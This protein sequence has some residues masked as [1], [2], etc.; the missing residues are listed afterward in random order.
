MSLI[1][2]N[3]DP[4]ARYSTSTRQYDNLRSTSDAS[5]QSR[6]S[7]LVLRR[8]ALVWPQ[9]GHDDDSIDVNKDLKIGI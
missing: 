1:G 8:R 4:S 2:H 6:V 5:C 7:S 3:G 9:L